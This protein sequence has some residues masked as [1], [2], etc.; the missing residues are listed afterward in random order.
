MASARSMGRP[1]PGLADSWD[2]AE[3]ELTYTFH[4]NQDA[5]WHDGVDFT[6]EDVAFSFDAALDPNT[7]FPYRSIV[8]DAVESYRVID[9][10]T[11]EMKAR[12]KAGHLPLRRSRRDH[13]HAEAHLGRCRA[14]SWS[15]DGGS[16][17]QIP[18]E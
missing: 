15:F 16:T 12:E 13:H 5:T 1:V 11:F 18:R 4:L 6:A 7:G 14:A 2:V 3:D 17:G 10:N 8:N 9:E